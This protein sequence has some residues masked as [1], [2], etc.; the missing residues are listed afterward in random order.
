MVFS[1]YLRFNFSSGQIHEIFEIWVQK[2]IFLNIFWNSICRSSSSSRQ[3][4]TSRSSSNTKRGS[5]TTES[6]LSHGVSGVLPDLTSASVSGSNLNHQ[7]QGGGHGHHHYHHHHRNVAERSNKMPELNW[8]PVG[9][10]ADSSSSHF[11][12]FPSISPSPNLF[13]SQDFGFDFST[14]MFGDM[15]GAT[16]VS[17]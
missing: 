2:W 3:P 15:H 13:S 14:S 10:A 17:R 16:P 5:Y 1:E 11:A 4:Q 8:N 6:L 12:S 7:S 9:V